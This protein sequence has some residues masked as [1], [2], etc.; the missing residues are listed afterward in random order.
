MCSSDLRGGLKRPIEAQM[1]LG[2][3]QLLA[4]RKEAGQATLRAALELAQAA[5]DP[6]LDA[7][8]LW[9]LYA[10]SL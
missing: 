3:A 5:K 7:V 2:V 9:H 4:G 10:S 1:H 8:R 6:L